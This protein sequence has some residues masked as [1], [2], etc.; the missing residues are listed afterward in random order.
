MFTGHSLSWNDPV[1]MDVELSAMEQ[2]WEWSGFPT[3]MNVHECPEASGLIA[4]PDDLSD[5][6]IWISM[7]ILYIS[8]S[9]WQRNIVQQCAN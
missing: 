6:D 9:Q 2:E 8:K 7:S 5:I 4:Q 1:L 3:A